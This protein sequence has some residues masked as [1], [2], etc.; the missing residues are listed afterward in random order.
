MF[1]IESIK[2][3]EDTQK[4]N[5]YRAKVISL[6]DPLKLNR[7][8]IMI[9]GLTDDF[10]TPD[11]VEDSPQPWCEL[12]FSSKLITYPNVDDVIW[13]FFEGGDIFRPIYVGTIYAGLN[14]S[15]EKGMEQFLNVLSGTTGNKAAEKEKFGYEI[16]NEFPENYLDQIKNVNGFSFTATVGD[17][18]N[19]DVVT[20]NSTPYRVFQEGGLFEVAA[21]KSRVKLSLTTGVENWQQPF[22]NPSAG[23][24]PAKYRGGAKVYVWYNAEK[25]GWEFKTQEEFEKA[26]HS[27]PDNSLR[28]NLIKYRNWVKTISNIAAAGPSN[29]VNQNLTP[30]SWY[31]IKATP[32][33]YTDPQMTVLPEKGKP[34]QSVKPIPSSP[35]AKMKLTDRQYY[36]Q[37]SWTSFD[38]KSSIELDD[39]DGYERMRLDFNNSDGFIEFSK[40]GHNGLEISTNEIFL[41]HSFS[42]NKKNMIETIGDLGIASEKQCNVGGKRGLGLYSDQGP[43]Y[44]RTKASDIT[45]VSKTG[46]NVSSFSGGGGGMEGIWKNSPLLVGP[47]SGPVTGGTHGFV[48]MISSEHYANMKQIYSAF[49]T[50]IFG[51]IN[52]AKK[53]LSNFPS[54]PTMTTLFCKTL[55]QFFKKLAVFAPI[56]SGVNFTD[57][58]VASAW[59]GIVLEGQGR[60]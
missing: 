3:L 8:Q 33:A 9:Y 38:R 57:L 49:N 22:T 41:I 56:A 40:K 45:F 35:F 2:N 29:E 6:N 27:F 39:N 16:T 14:I 21:A 43:V 7:I 44:C 1:D 60:I 47:A 26:L 10:E 11:N 31:F 19:L 28:T 20:I 46:F 51:L 12:Q 37:S 48:P 4:S 42:K 24:M 17:T 25:E 15:A 18:Y 5:F 53:E 36:K 30:E 52:C 55:Y 32:Y 23:P 59:S 13:L 34:K 50:V 58:S 54:D